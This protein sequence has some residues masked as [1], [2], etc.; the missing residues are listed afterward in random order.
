MIFGYLGFSVC[1]GV[2]GFDL[3]CAL[4]SNFEIIVSILALLII[5][6]KRFEKYV[7][8]VYDKYIS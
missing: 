8:I 5:K 3:S 6:N 4:F 2:S 7:N 1:L